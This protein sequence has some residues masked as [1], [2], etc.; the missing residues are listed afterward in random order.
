M[1]GI[2]EGMVCRILMFVCGLLAPTGAAMLF[3]DV[4]IF[5]LLSLSG[6]FLLKLAHD[7]PPTPTQKKEGHPA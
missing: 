6:C 7:R 1:R 2:P 4:I 3:T 5:L